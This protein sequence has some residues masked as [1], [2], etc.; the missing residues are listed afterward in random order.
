MKESEEIELKDWIRK[1]LILE[2]ETRKYSN[3]NSV[4]I[5]L[6][7]KCDADSFIREYINILPTN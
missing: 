7:L 2:V 1:N 4:Y 5:G 6:R 3:D